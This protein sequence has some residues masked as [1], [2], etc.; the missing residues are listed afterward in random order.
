MRVISRG[1]LLLVAATRV[2]ALTAAG[3]RQQSIYQVVV[4]RFARTDLSTTASCDTSQQVY[5]GGTWRGLISKLD[6]IQGMGFTAVWISPVV[7][8]MDGNTQDGSSYHGYWAQD[9]WSLNSAFGSESDLKALSA[10]LHDRGMYLMVDVVTN[11]MAYRGCG[12]CVDY[13]V[14]KPFS[15]ASYYHPFCFID[16]NI[17]SSIE[18][19]WQ[20]SNTVSLPDL[21]TEN[22]DVRR[23]WNQW[24]SSMVSKYSIDGIRIDSAKHVE[25]S[26]WAGFKA[27]AGVYVTGEVFNGDP[28]IVA[29][30]QKYMDGVLDYPSYYWVLRAFQ[31]TSGSV[32]ELVN[33]LAKLK[34]NALDL[35]LFGSF[36]EN[37]DVERFPSFTSDMALTKNA[38]AFT[39]VKDGIPITYQGQEQHYAGNG[40]PNNRE[41]L[42]FSAYSTSSEL[43][44]WITK[45]NKI[46]AWAITQDAGYISQTMQVVYSDSH[47]IATRKGFTGSQV[48]GVF[49]N[50]GSGSSSTIKLVS[51]GTGFGAGQTVVD[52]LSCTAL[53]TDLS[54]NIIATITSGIPRVLYPLARLL[55]SGICPLLGGTLVPTS[56]GPAPAPASTTPTVTSTVT[57]TL[58][59]WSSTV[60]M[61]W[62]S[63]SNSASSPTPTPTAPS[64]TSTTVPVTFQVLASTSFGDTVKMHVAPFPL[65]AGDITALGSWSASNAPALSASRYTTSNPHWWATVNLAPGSV[66]QY[67][68][69]KV[70][71]SGAVTWEPDPNRAYTVACAAATVLSTWRS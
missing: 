62:I 53:T 51:S 17:Q 38:I 26:F 57:M 31:S 40:T 54:G 24:I 25:T 28:L 37:H 18:T 67:K 36:L 4:D 12:T 5:C 9:I 45:L 8:Q 15:S 50:I 33:G 22:D 55:G 68:F 49:S 48:V 23:I 19:C 58:T 56:L 27:A 43:Y 41:A 6:Y 11:H 69:I 63:G 14:L 1:L 13:S 46:R 10:A 65:C 16:Y 71:S 20:G 61:T 47:T 2:A 35:S 44:T 64:C 60:T 66:P 29:P 52:V 70:T 3:W 21:R 39:M 7:K 42:W 34:S 30:Y 32:S 59:S